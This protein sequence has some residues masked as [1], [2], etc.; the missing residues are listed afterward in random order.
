M[1]KS[2]TPPPPVALEGRDRTGD[3]RQFSPSAARNSGPIREVVERALPRSGAALEIGSGTGE[4]IVCFAKALPGL[5]WLPSD[6]DPA[7]RASIEAWIACEGLANVRAPVAIDT[8]QA[9]W[10]VEDDAPFAAMVSLN[11]VHIAPW[12]A[13]LGLLAGAGRLLRPDGILYFYGPF[14]TGGRHTAP[15]N[16]AFDADL[17]RRDPRWGLRNVDDLVREAVPH[18]LELREV[19]EMP[20]NNL[21]LVFVR[22]GR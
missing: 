2:E 5:V 3:G 9:A 21:S 17:K 10:G 19:I 1:T 15:S 12:Q 14:M 6:P 11:M 16:A 4:H 8:S 20:A 7:A 22:T 18:G 13:A